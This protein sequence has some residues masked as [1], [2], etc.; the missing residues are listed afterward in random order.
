VSQQASGSATSGA[1]NPDTLPN[2]SDP[3]GKCPRC[4]RVAHFT[5]VRSEGLRQGM[6]G[7]T[8]GDI[9]LATVLEC[10]GCHGK[11]LVVD[12]VDSFHVGGVTC[13]GVMWWPTD[14]LG[15]LQ[16]VA[17]VP[18][19]IVTAYSEGVRC[20]AVQAPNAAVAMF[21]TVIAQIVADKGS[22]VA[23]AK[24]TLF[25]RIEQMVQ[26][27]TLWDDFGDWAH[28]VRDTGNAGAHGEKFDPV[29]IDQ[30]TELQTFIREM[31]N[32]LYEQPARRAAARPATKKANPAACGGTAP[33]GASGTPP[34]SGQA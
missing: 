3:W 31:L 2:K 12:V 34:G 15:D 4:G 19:D 33:A 23:K 16:Q 29:T 27:K 13:H 6:I 21:R 14:H 22:A 18:K 30:A 1:P 10:H 24:R 26:E 7:S 9:E 25:E 11:S 8:G 32:F 28:H 17:G 20:L 5:V